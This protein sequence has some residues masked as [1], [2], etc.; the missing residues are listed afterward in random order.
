MLDGYQS[1]L[2]STTD[3]YYVGGDTFAL[4]SGHD[5]NCKAA[6][7][8][9]HRVKTTMK[10]VHNLNSIEYLDACARDD[11]SYHVEE[12]MRRKEC[13]CHSQFFTLATIYRFWKCTS[14]TPLDDLG[15]ADAHVPNFGNGKRDFWFPHSRV[16]LD[17]ELAV[18]MDPS[19]QPYGLNHGEGQVCIFNDSADHLIGLAEGRIPYE[20]DGNIDYQSISLQFTSATFSTFGTYSDLKSQVRDEF[21]REH[22][23]LLKGSRSNIDPFLFDLYTSIKL[24]EQFGQKL[25]H[26]VHLKVANGTSSKAFEVLDW[27]SNG[28]TSNSFEFVGSLDWC[29]CQNLLKCP[30]GTVTNGDSAISI[31][32]CISTKNEFLHRLSLLE[33]QAP[34]EEISPYDVAILTV[35]QSMLPHNLTYG[36]HYRISVY[37]GCKPCPLRYQ[38][39]SAE[40]SSCIYPPTTKQH[41]H[42]NQCLKD[43]RKTV[44]LQADGSLEAV[45]KC[46]QMANETGAGSTNRQFMLFSEPDIEKCLSRPYYCSDSEWGYLTFRRLCQDSLPNGTLSPVYDCADVLRW[47]V[48]SRWRDKICCSS[49]PELRGIDSCD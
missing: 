29:E 32:G 7:R 45:E 20:R 4:L 43:T 46:Q 3:A 36:E 48:Y 18:E 41:E 17:K 2:S 49:V 23:Q 47:D 42:F 28:T 8:L 44:C 9:Q 34:P 26:T 33:T 11:K 12:A 25:E 30:N 5:A 37:D 13:D 10:D 21:A 31:D 1:T 22:E 38:C 6:T 27:E 24:I 19:M 40:S 14:V 35:D 39:H 16:H 15:L